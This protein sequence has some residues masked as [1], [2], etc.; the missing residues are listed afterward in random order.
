MTARAKLIVLTATTAFTATFGGV[1]LPVDAQDPASTTASTPTD[2]ATTSTATPTDTATASTPTPTDTATSSTPTTS[3]PTT[4]TPTTTQPDRSVGTGLAGHTKRGSSPQRTT[5]KTHRTRRHRSHRAKSE[6]ESAKDQTATEC[7]QK[8]AAAARARRLERRRKKAAAA[9]VSDARSFLGG[10]GGQRLPSLAKTASS[11]NPCPPEADQPTTSTPTSSGA[12]PSTPDATAPAPAP[13]DPTTSVATPGPVPV[14]VPNFFIEKFRIPPFLLPIYQAAGIQYNVPWQV[15]AAIN[16]IETDYG[17]NLSVS[18]AGARGWMQFLPSSWKT[19]GVDANDDGRKDPYNPA[20]AIFAAARYLKAAGADQDVRKAIFAYNHASWYVD[21]VMLRA[22]L[23]GGLPAG[24]VGSLTG[25][26]QGHF[27]V[28]ARAKYADHHQ[29]STDIFARQGAPVIAVQDG[30]VKKIGSSTKKGRYLV[31]QDAYGNRYTYAHLGSVQSDYPVP[32]PTNVSPADVAK[33]LRLPNDPEP[34]EAAS[35]GRQHQP[36]VKG[37]TKVTKQRVAARAAN[38]K[39]TATGKTASP[40]AAPAAAPT[41]SV[42]KE[43]L[44]AHPAR[45]PAYNAGGKQQL[46]E[47]GKLPGFTTFKDYF[48]SVFGLNRKDVELKPLRKG[49]QVIAGTIL[50][51]IGEAGQTSP[52]IEFAIQPAG[53]KAPQID[54]KP[55]LDGWKLLESTAI[56]RAAGKN[57][58]F[59]SDGRSPTIGQVLLM[60]KEQLQ[61]RVLEDP[62]I[63]IYSCGREDIRTGQIDR[64]VLATLEFLADSDLRPTV[65]ALKCGHSYLTTSGNVSEHTSGDAVDIAA[66]NGTPILDHQG[67]GS[68]TDTTI[69]RLLALQGAMKPHQIISL[70]TP[71]DFGGADNILSLPDHYNHIHVGFHPDGTTGGADNGLNPRQWPHLIEQLKNIDNPTVPTRPSHD[72]IPDGD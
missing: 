57:P 60:S 53:K 39:S 25:L 44:Y 33:E 5:K 19:Y 28:H 22:K 18:S 68:I 11:K 69:Q 56:Y 72:A 13:S 2:A 65:S 35:A 24:L 26:T 27:P 20:D 71:E 38:G 43:R 1:V 58:F 46:F 64:R 6:T 41:V 16:E 52:H 51:R 30:V 7:K 50:G 9:G 59:G 63:D 49:S 67:K 23:I 47:A 3:T 62:R 10:G 70:M 32:K 37:K 8:A 21:S 17:R 14:G 34:T 12:A 54:P 48:T 36:Q 42:Q 15:L 61:Q 31:L 45:R 4:S 66:I 40:A 29:S 55:I